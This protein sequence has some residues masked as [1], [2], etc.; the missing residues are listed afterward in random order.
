VTRHRKIALILHAANGLLFLALGF[1]LFV[2]AQAFTSCTSSAIAQ[3][4]SLCVY[5]SLV[6]F[7]VPI[8]IALLPII[9]LSTFG[10]TA[11]RFLW[12][13]SLF[14][15]VLFFPIGTAVGVHTLYLLRSTTVAASSTAD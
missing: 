8:M 7:G 13:Y 6:C 14:I 15:A 10:K 11:R 5:A 1:T 4:P 12:G 2:L 3:S 9:A